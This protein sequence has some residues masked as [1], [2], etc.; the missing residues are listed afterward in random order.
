MCQ[1]NWACLEEFVSEVAGQEKQSKN[2]SFWRM[3]GQH[4]TEVALALLTRQPQ[5][6]LN[7][8]PIFF[9]REKLLDVAEIYWRPCL[10]ASGQKLESILYKLVAS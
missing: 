6:R 7:A 3:A 5:V 4:S 2:Q 9:P 1:H 8:L 10:E